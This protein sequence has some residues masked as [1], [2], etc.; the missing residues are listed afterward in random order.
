MQRTLGHVGRAWRQ[1]L[2][3][4]GSAAASIDTRFR[5]ARA[6]VV[7]ALA[8]SEQERWHARCDRLAAKLGLCDEREAAAPGER[9][10]AAP[11]AH[12]LASRW[13]AH[14]ALPAAWQQAL[15]DRW[16]Q[17]VAPGPLTEA[18]LGDV[19]LQFEAAL[20][21]PTTPEL[22]AARRGL[23]LQALKAAL[24]GR[25]SREANPEIE[26]AQW[27]AAA[28]RQGVPGAA[29][30]ERLLAVI[31]ALRRLLPGPDPADAS[32]QTR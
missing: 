28:L 5:S 18:A 14:D 25:A 7:Q 15:D 13:A 2:E 27:L 24:E 6:A 31:A 22:Q 30:G 29:H 32:D 4:P 16:S 9:E 3:L 11:G 8:H 17:P 21:M 20:D 23:K 10:A 1:P 12:V 19:W 26:R